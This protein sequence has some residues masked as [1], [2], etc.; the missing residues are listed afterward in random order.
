[1][2]AETP[3]RYEGPRALAESLS[4]V[5]ADGR[6]RRALESRGTARRRRVS[7]PGSCRGNRGA[8]RRQAHPGAEAAAG[9]H[10]LALARHDGAL[11]LRAARLAHVPLRRRR[12]RRDACTPATGCRSRPA[13]RTT[14]SRA[15]TTSRCS[16]STSPPSTGRG[17]CRNRPRRG[18]ERIRRCA[19]ARSPRG[20]RKRGGAL[21]IF[22]LLFVVWE[23]AVRL[24]GVKEYLLPPPSKVWTEF[25]KRHDDR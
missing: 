13:C 5:R 3:P 15:P 17:T 23:V 16:R 8:H 4:R 21:A 10:R 9:A 24:T 14:W 7:R 6:C 11:R 2:P 22:V 19:A 20:S 12:R 25:W 18:G 1:M